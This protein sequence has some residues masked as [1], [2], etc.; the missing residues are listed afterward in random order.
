MING[1]VDG[2]GNGTNLELLIMQ[3]LNNNNNI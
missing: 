2:I 3:N 1:L